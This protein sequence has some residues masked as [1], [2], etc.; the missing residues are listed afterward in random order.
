MFALARAESLC[1]VNLRCM[2]KSLRQWEKSLAP[3]DEGEAAL[4]Y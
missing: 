4:D 3:R 2:M 1:G